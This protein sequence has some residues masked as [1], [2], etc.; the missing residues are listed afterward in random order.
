MAITQHDIDVASRVLIYQEDGLYV[1]HALDWDLIGC[2]AT[3][4]K[5]LAELRSNVLA[6]ITLAIHH[7]SPESFFRAAPEEFVDRWHAARKQAVSQLT[8]S[9]QQLSVKFVATFVQVSA[10]EIKSEARR[11]RYE[12]P[13][14]G[15]SFATA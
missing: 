3:K 15:R 11:Q 9:E 1:A 4:K 8:K 13:A 10:D 5:A 7:N 6:Q 14:E 2:G 12:T